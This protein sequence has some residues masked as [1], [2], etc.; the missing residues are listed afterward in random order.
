MIC[1]C[2]PY[3]LSLAIHTNNHFAS[4]WFYNSTSSQYRT[5]NQILDFS[6]LLVK[7]VFCTITNHLTTIFLMNRHLSRS[8]TIYSTIILNSTRNDFDESIQNIKQIDTLKQIWNITYNSHSMIHAAYLY[9]KISNSR[10]SLFPFE[11]IR[12]VDL[13]DLQSVISTHFLHNLHC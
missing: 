4:I 9:H 12:C 3:Q 13:D 11:S 6:S 8:Y 10:N 5:F 7:L 1:Y 2:I